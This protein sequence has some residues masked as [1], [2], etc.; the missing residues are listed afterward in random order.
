MPQAPL[1]GSIWRPD[2]SFDAQ[3]VLM[4]RGNQSVW[5]DLMKDA[6][7]MPGSRRVMFTGSAH[8]HWF[9][10][11][12]GIVDPDQGFNFPWV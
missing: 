12:V 2:L 1:H 8:H 9:A 3:Q 5:P 7:G 11:S 10:G 4:F 6:R